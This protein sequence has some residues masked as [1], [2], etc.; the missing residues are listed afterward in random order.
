M[1][2]K[3]KQLYLTKLLFPLLFLVLS[4]FTGCSTKTYHQTLSKKIVLKTSTWRF[5]DTGFLRLNDDVADLE[6]IALGNSVLKLSVYADQVCQGIG[7][8]DTKTFNETYLN[9]HYP[10][11]LFDDLLRAKPLFHGKNFVQQTDG[12]E[13]VVRTSGKYN[14]LYRVRS[15]KIYFKDRQSNILIKIEDLQKQ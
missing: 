15:G 3:I 13:Q 8:I 9:P 1:R 14:I 11:T 7:C 10:K 5:A 4:L 12:F 6:I 2:V